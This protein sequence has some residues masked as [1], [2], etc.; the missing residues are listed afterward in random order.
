MIARG[1]A[2]YCVL[3][4][5]QPRMLI[6]NATF[7]AQRRCIVLGEKDWNFV[8]YVDWWA[9]SCSVVRRERRL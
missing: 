5:P 9:T 8:A 2:C 7:Q 6:N 3:K 4:Q 1:K